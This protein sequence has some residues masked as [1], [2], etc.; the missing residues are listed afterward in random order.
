M[1]FRSFACRTLS[2]A[3]CN[4]STGVNDNLPTSSLT[5]NSSNFCCCFIV[6]CLVSWF[7]V[8]SVLFVGGC[9]ACVGADVDTSACVNCTT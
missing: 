8:R 6:G 2:S 1:G 7:V 5:L 9:Q 4:F 3:M